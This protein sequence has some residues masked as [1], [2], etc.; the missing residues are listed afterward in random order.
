MA[1]DALAALSTGGHVIGSRPV[2]SNAKELMRWSGNP[3][4]WPSIQ[5]CHQH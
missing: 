3:M 1:L 4:T 5:P 2:A